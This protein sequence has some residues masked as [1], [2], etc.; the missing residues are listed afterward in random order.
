MYKVIA[1]D[2]KSSVTLLSGIF[3][4]CVQFFEWEIVKLVSGIFSG[5]EQFI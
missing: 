4:W 1:A 2:Q 3:T 5:V